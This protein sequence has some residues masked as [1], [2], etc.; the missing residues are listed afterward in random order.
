MIKKKLLILGLS[1]MM[2][3]GAAGCGK[4]KE[5]EGATEGTKESSKTYSINVSETPMLTGDLSNVE[6]SKDGKVRSDLTGEWI[7]KELARRKP[8]ACTVENTEIA[9]PQSGIENADI[10]YEMMEEGGI[11]RLVCLFTDY[12]NIPK[13]GPMRSVRYY[14]VRKVVEHQAV[15]CHWGKAA[16][17]NADLEGYPGVEHVDFNETEGGYRVDRHLSEDWHGAYISGEAVNNWRSQQPYQLEKNEF[18]QKMLNFNAT[19]TEPA[20]GE[21]ANKITTALSEASTGWFEYDPET[22]EYKRFMFGAPQIDDESGNQLHVKN[23]IVVFTYHGLY[24]CPDGSENVSGWI[25][26]ELVGSGDGFYASDGK[27]IPIKWEKGSDAR[28]VTQFY[29]T[30]GQPLQI[31]P[32]KSWITYMQEDN[33][34]GLIVE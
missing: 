12:D 31:N 23:I 17:A 2:T 11:D 9:F 16:N 25:D 10:Y 24:V 1:L 18:Y 28:D 7:D 8:I 6:V 22:K 33:K 5:D 20:G 32:G 4:D 27:I 21:T 3:F 19:D 30:D 13:I 26:V 14:M 34:A 29:T 15:L